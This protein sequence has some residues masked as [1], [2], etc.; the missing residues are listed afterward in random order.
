MMNMGIDSHIPGLTC[1][2]QDREMDIKEIFMDEI[3]K[4]ALTRWQQLWPTL[5]RA[6]RARI[7]G[8]RG[9]GKAGDPFGGEQKEIQYGRG[10][11]ARAI[12]YIRDKLFAPTGKESAIPGKRSKITR[13]QTLKD[14]P[15]TESIK[16]RLSPRERKIIEKRV[17]GKSGAFT[18]HVP[19]V[20]RDIRKGI[21]IGIS[22]PERARY[23]HLLTPAEKALNLVAP[24]H[25][26]A[27]AHAAARPHVLATERTL[28]EIKR[29]GGH[30]L[31]KAK[32]DPHFSR[33][34]YR[35]MGLRTDASHAGVEPLVAEQ[36]AAYGSPKTQRVVSELRMGG[37]ERP[38]LTS[39]KEHGWTPQGGLPSRPGLYEKIESRGGDRSLRMQAMAKKLQKIRRVSDRTVSKKNKK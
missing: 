8:S 24:A 35:K 15:L 9:A 4:L 12:R 6:S 22:L 25:E 3:D 30:A 18:V 21:D 32:A 36:E 37:P 7:A 10:P 29:K 1:Y 20:K 28:D 2:I 13:E 11:A 5:S 23:R 39:M 31:K 26:R 14:Y 19:K 27:E 33:E 38:W 17:E 16:S 34:I